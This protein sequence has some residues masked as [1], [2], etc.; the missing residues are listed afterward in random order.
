MYLQRGGLETVLPLSPPA[1]ILHYALPGLTAG[2]AF[3]A[4]DFIQVNGELN[5]L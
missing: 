1:T 2:I 4:T 5:R 3:A